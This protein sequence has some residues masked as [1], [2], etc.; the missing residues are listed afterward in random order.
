MKYP[1]GIQQFEKM[2]K[3]GFVYVDKSVQI[4]QLAA[5]GSVFHF[6]VLSLRQQRF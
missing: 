1:I 2:R 5:R 6:F 4:Y 3:N